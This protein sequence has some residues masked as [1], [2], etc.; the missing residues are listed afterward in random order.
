MLNMEIR[1]LNPQQVWEMRQQVLW[2]HKPLDY[3]ILPQDH[4]GLHF[5]G[6]VNGELVTVVSLFIEGE[7]AQFRKF[8]TKTEHQGKGYGSLLL[9]VVL[10]EATL[11]GA[12]RIWCNARENKASYYA[13]FG[14]AKKGQSLEKDGVRYVMMEAWL[15][16]AL[17]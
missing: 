8:A 4:E 7:E 13:R 14:L 5:G 11:K 9:R 16:P 15:D 1:Q 10:E 12:R 17:T 2:P 3:V 6:F